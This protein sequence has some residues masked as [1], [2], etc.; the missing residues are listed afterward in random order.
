MEFWDNRLNDWVDEWRQTN[1]LPR[2]VMFTLKQADN[3]RARGAQE[4]VT[5][6]VSIP[7]VAV[8][9][10]WELPRG[11]P[12]PGGP[13][14][15]GGVPPGTQPGIVPPNQPGFQ[16]GMQPGFQPGVQPGMFPSGPVPTPR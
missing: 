11:M 4:E 3:E 9:P 13:L 15:P 8:Q 1:Q 12:G 7:A 2:L 16:P 10:F 5:R 14:Q 6:I